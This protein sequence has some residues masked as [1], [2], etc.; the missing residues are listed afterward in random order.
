MN[1]LIYFPSCVLELLSFFFVL[2]VLFLHFLQ[3]LSDSAESIGPIRRFGGFS[4]LAFPSEGPAH[5]HGEGCLPPAVP[6]HAS[7]NGLRSLE[8]SME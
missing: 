3:S 2:C 7:L 4:Q 6:S 1:P 5:L 8:H